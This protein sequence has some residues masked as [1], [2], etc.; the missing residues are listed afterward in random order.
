VQHQVPRFRLLAAT[1]LAT[2]AASGMA[3]AQQMRERQL[4]IT[5]SGRIEYDTNV[6]RASDPLQ[7][8]SSGSKSDIRYT[9][10]LDL[11]IY[12]PLSRQA[13]F[14]GGSIGY[15]FYHR[16]TQLNSERISLRGGADYQLGRCSGTLSADYARQ[17]SDLGDF[18]DPFTGDLLTGDNIEERRA[19]DFTVGCSR[20]FGLRPIASA[21]YAQERNNSFAR[22]QGD[23]NSYYGQ[24]GIGY[25]G[26]TFGQLSLIGRYQKISYPNRFALVG[27][28]LVK[29]GLEVKSAGLSY[30]RELGTRLRASGS[31]TY[32]WV[33]PKLQGTRDFRGLSWSGDLTWQGSSMLV[34]AGLAR[35]VNPSNLIDVAYEV[36][37]NYYINTSYAASQ[38]LRL[39]AG[40]SYSKRLLN[41]SP[42]VPTLFPRGD[43]RTYQLTGGVTY[44]FR[45]RLS[46]GTDV[47][48]EWRQSTNDFFKYSSTRFGAT[49]RLTF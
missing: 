27:N 32:T 39:N 30:E 31:L 6:L 3:S 47:T 1:L 42:A 49:A 25:V 28:E 5:A 34:S 16:N 29:D 13:V 45:R 19:V 23:S 48:H 22:R 9:P 15:D 43:D 24:V 20:P 12:L 11:D 4:D 38:A 17:L 14:L 21:G 7:V 41:E 44:Q 2:C 46:V 36:E 35:T 33:D 40:A 26:P 8:T 37:E 18:F 10:S